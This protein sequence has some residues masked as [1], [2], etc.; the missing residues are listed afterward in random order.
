MDRKAELL[1]ILCRQGNLSLACLTTHARPLAAFGA[2]SAQHQPATLSRHSGPESMGLLAPAVIGL[3]RPLHDLCVSGRWFS[4][5]FILQILT[6]ESKEFHNKSHRKA[7]GSFRVN[8]CKKSLFLC[9]F[10]KA[11]LHARRRELQSNCIYPRIP[12]LIKYVTG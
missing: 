11:A 6:P 5:V 7:C 3:E 8:T 10:F 12:K 4:K 1:T 2:P 9:G